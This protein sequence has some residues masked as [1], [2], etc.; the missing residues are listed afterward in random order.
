MTHGRS[1]RHS[2]PGPWGQE[3][4]H[5][6]H[7]DGRYGLIEVPREFS[8]YQIMHTVLGYHYRNCV[9]N[10]HSQTGNRINQGYLTDYNFK[11]YSTEMG[12]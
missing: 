8:V 11:G 4:A 5:T 3:R 12:C 1:S 10:Y 6:V 9:T 7:V 2:R